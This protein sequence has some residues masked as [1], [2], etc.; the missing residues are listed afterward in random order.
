MEHT[1][2]HVSVQCVEI[3]KTGWEDGT[4]LRHTHTDIHTHTHTHTVTA[5]F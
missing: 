2:T 3:S 1:Y 4:A 5:V